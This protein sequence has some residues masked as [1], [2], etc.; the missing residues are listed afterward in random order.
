MKTDQF[1]IENV[2]STQSTC[3]EREV[4]DIFV[5]RKKA[6]NRFLKNALHADSSTENRGAASCYCQIARKNDLIAR[7]EML[8]FYFLFKATS[9]TFS[10]R[11]ATCPQTSSST[12][13][14]VYARNA[15]VICLNM[16]EDFE[17]SIAHELIQRDL[18]NWCQQIM[19]DVK[20]LHE[21]FLLS[22]L[23]V[24]NRKNR[25]EIELQ[26]LFLLRELYCVSDGDLTRDRSKFN[27]GLTDLTSLNNL[28]PY[29]LACEVQTPI[30]QQFGTCDLY[31]LQKVLS[32]SRIFVK[33]TDLNQ[34]RSATLKDVQ[35]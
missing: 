34:I 11:S 29:D 3:R 20:H 32:R 21:L 31:E 24:I 5:A 28:I 4:Y 27:S 8:K 15:L 2:D 26:I 14:E 13:Q 16:L 7:L 35:K 1:T 12:L 18:N 25:E 30:A 23:Q 17:S 22:H 33:V 9:P 10:I 6:L 19:N